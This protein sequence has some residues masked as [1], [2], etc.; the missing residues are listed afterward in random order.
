MSSIKERMDTAFQ[1]Y[2]DYLDYCK[3]WMGMVKP[4][5]WGDDWRQH[6][7]EM[8]EDEAKT[9]EA[10]AAASVPSKD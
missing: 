10:D 6:W 7:K 8:K 3:G 1:E 2:S 5:W 9:A 4:L